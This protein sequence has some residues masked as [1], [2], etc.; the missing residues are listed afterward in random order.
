MLGWLF[1]H[2]PIDPAEK[3]WTET[4]MLWLAQQF[5]A[6]RLL[7]ARVV[8]PEDLFLDAYNGS[9]EDAQQ[10]LTCMCATLETDP[11][12]YDLEVATSQ[13]QS[14]PEPAP[15]QNTIRLSD[16]QLGSPYLVAAALGRELAFRQL[17]PQD[18]KVSAAGRVDWLADLAAVFLGWGV[19]VGHALADDVAGA[20]NCGCGPGPV[21]NLSPARILGYAL[22]LFTF[23]R[24]ETRPTWKS[25]LRLETSAAFSRS[26][27]YLRRTNDTLFTLETAGQPIGT[28]PTGE[29]LQQLKKGSRSA[30][31]A[32]LWELRDA[33]HATEAAEPVA[34]YLHDS[35][36]VLRE[37]S[38][39]TLAEYGPADQDTLRTLIDLL[40]DYRDSIR[41][42][43]ARSLGRVGT[44]SA[45]A[46]TQLT[47]LLRDP[48]RQ[49]VFATAVAI[50][51]FGPPGAKAIPALLNALRDA[52]VRCDHELIDTLTHSLYALEPD[53]TERVLE[54]FADDPELRQQVVHIIVDALDDDGDG[55]VA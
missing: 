34:S 45:E 51:K 55:Q 16:Q 37:E 13:C 11:A 7:A 53:P 33:R 4:R 47:E 31:V 14:G 15:P 2:A 10:I 5:G 40:Q 28:R 29:L 42:A 32:A 17:P 26:E 54:Y 27:N 9:L 50:E 41:A 22:A 23:A 21:S 36:P 48:V 43:A 3:A 38:A 49:V 30:R 18:F 44:E 39:H 35:L 19:V 24:D 25:E 8:L 6:P 52:V 12:H 20:Q 46:L 1:P